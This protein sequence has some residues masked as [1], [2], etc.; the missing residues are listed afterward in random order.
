[1]APLVTCLVISMPN[2]M[3]HQKAALAS[4]VNFDRCA[5]YHD[6]G[7]GKTFTGAEKLMSFQNPLNLVVC[8][9][10][11]ISDWVEHFK[12]YYLAPVYDLTKKRELDAY[13]SAGAG[14]GVINYEQLIRRPQLQKLTGLAV[15]FDESS[16][17]KNEQSKRTKCALALKAKHVVL[18]SGTPV[19]GKYE[20]LWSQCRLLGWRIS[21]EDFWA[22]FICFKEWSPAPYANP[23]KLVTGYKNVAQLKQSLR[24]HG[25]HFLKS[26]DVISL[27]DQVFQTIKVGASK[28]YGQLMANGFVEVNGEELLADMPLKKL[29]YARE[30]CSVYSADKLKAFEDWLNSTSG[31][32][33]VFYN[34]TGELEA[35]K[36]V[37]GKSRPISV[38]NGTSKDLTAYELAQDSIIFIQYQ[39]GALGLNLQLAQHV[40][41]FSPPL[42]SELYEQS[43]KRVHRIGQAKTCF[44]YLFVCRDTVEEQIYDTLQKRKDYTLRLF[45]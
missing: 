12:S 32:L 21:K 42:S 27:P 45:T 38:V 13:V 35:L 10:S 22:R 20:E 40:G 24:E 37:V 18:L 28:E 23:I 14:V 44:Y 34:F 36:H 41:Y 4:V 8:Q 7:L 19:G 39:A 2:L 25:A 30:L 16:M 43:K 17:L 29:L 3:E 5:F 1:M 6:M 33:V 31:R 9:K 11:K 15:V 26:E